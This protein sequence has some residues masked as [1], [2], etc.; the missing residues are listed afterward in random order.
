MKNEQN[1]GRNYLFLGGRFFLRYMYFDL[2]TNGNYIA[3]SLFYKRKISVKFEK[4]LNRNGDKYR[5]VF[6]RIRKKDRAAFEE[7]L[8]EIRTKM[9]LLGH[10]DYDEYCDK[11]M[12]MLDK[13]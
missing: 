12:A 5:A 9:S 6:C 1:D 8:E 7:A 3:D 2:D 4:E 13:A 10:N 11:V